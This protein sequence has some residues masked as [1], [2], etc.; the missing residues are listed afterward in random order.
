MKPR[1]NSSQYA[2]TTPKILS[3]NSLAMNAPRDVCVATSALHTGTIALRCPVP[4]PLMMRAQHILWAAAALALRTKSLNDH[5]T[6]QRS[7]MRVLAQGPGARSTQAHSTDVARD[8]PRA[9]RIARQGLHPATSKV[10]H[11][12]KSRVRAVG[13]AGR[14]SAPSARQWQ[15]SPSGCNCAIGIWTVFVSTPAGRASRRPCNLMSGDTTK[16]LPLD[17]MGDSLSS[18]AYREQFHRGITDMRP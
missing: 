14:A 2:T 8:G 4:I 6:K 18:R 16:A 1:P 12:P 13:W 3:V 5:R 17:E 7:R 15:L 10:D 9:G 11:F